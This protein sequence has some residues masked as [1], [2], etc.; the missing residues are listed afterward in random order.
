MITQ[1]TTHG[2]SAIKDT[3]SRFTIVPERGSA[4][5]RPTTADELSGWIHFYVDTSSAG[6]TDLNSVEI[7]FN[8][9]SAT[10]ETVT[11]YERNKE[12]FNEDNLGKADAFTLPI[13]PGHAILSGG[14]TGVSI[15]VQFDNLASKI[16]VRSVGVGF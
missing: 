2:I 1:A 9:Q 7:N 14:P 3:R 12:I 16:Y 15:K 5:I 13:A 10:V 6:N 8:S 11:I 4:V